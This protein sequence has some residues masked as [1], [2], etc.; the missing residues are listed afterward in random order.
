[1][2]A[3]LTPPL[4]PAQAAPPPP[5]PSSRSRRSWSARARTSRGGRASPSPRTCAAWWSR[6]SLTQWQPSHSTSAHCRSLCRDR[7]GRQRDAGRRL[8][9]APPHPLPAP[10]AVAHT[11]S[12]AVAATAAATAML[13]AGRPT[14][15]AVGVSVGGRIIPVAHAPAGSRSSQGHHSGYAGPVAVSTSAVSSPVAPPSRKDEGNRA[16]LHVLAWLCA[17]CLLVIGQSPDA[18]E[19]GV[20]GERGRGA[21]GMMLIRALPHSNSPGACLLGMELRG[22]KP[23]VITAVVSPGAS[24]GGGAAGVAGVA[25]ALRG[26]PSARQQ[27][28]AGNV[29]VRERDAPPP[30]VG[31]VQVR[32]RW[33]QEER[34]TRILTLPLPSLPSSDIPSHRLTGRPRPHGPRALR[35]AR[36]A[37]HGGGGDVRP[38]HDARHAHDLHT[39]PLVDWRGDWLVCIITLALLP[40]PSCRRAR[41]PSSPP[42][43]AATRT[44][45]RRTT[46]VR[47]PY[48]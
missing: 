7:C 45:R 30:Y 17:R 12:L 16:F 6:G 4:L 14:A 5:P 21:E 3:P 46:G 19:W 28:E 44:T 18:R 47:S 34:S 42:S 27:L 29:F 1:M 38:L 40:P 41:S 2:A 48:R 43:R 25:S 24:G 8:T 31:S 13:A 9:R 20:G 15:A 26:G 23:L 32:R 22:P 39:G 37:A 35:Q 11:H 10:Q 36:R 33:W